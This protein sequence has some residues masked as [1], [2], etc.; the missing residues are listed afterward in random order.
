MTRVRAC[1]HLMTG[2]L[3]MQV[4]SRMCQESVMI[5]GSEAGCL[6]TV[7]QIQGDKVSLLI[8]HSASGKPGVLDSWTTHLARDATVKVGNIAEVTL[9]DVRKDKARLGVNTTTDAS[10]HRLEVWEAIQQEN[11]DSGGEPDDP[12]GSSVPQPPSP[13]PPSLDVRL[14]EPPVDDGGVG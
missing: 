6:L 10:V 1:P 13:K 5:S 14:D 7:L 2:E 3:V 9:V 12:A 4:L 8:S 11:R